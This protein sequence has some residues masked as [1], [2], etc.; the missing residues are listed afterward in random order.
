MSAKLSRSL[1]KGIVK[2]CLVEILEEGL[3]SS[4]TSL[5]ESRQRKTSN[6]SRQQELK[7]SLDQSRR[8]R[9]SAMDNVSW[10]SSSQEKNKMFESRLEQTTKSMT[11]DPVLSDILADTA[12][13]TLQEQTSVGRAGP[14]GAVLPTVRGSGDTA[15]RQAAVSDPTELFSEASGKW[16]D[17]AFAPSINK[18]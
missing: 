4:L 17:L 14:G 9:S 6:S 2:E 3:S 8:A 10:E 5:N 16:A 15:A 18:G 11:S 12:R 1:L 7:K 13:T